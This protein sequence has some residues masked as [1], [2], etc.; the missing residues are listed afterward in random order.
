MFRELRR[1]KQSLP[2]EEV[3]AILKRN[4]SG[5]L[6]VLGDEGYPY[7][8]PVS[9]VYEDY[10]I[11]FHCAM[12]GHKIDAI[13]HCDKVSFCVI[14]QDDIVPEKFT[15]FYKSVIA[16]GRAKVLEGEEKYHAIDILCEKY[17]PNIIGRKEEI[18]SSFE[19]LT[20]I[21]IKIEHM[22]GKAAIELMNQ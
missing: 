12:T 11:Y 19:H 14:D 17:S 21:E 16:F 5:T 9:Y 18:E 7:A 22:T 8:V 13:H 3:E 6:A 15:T 4:T 10:K 1:T 20:M 2:L